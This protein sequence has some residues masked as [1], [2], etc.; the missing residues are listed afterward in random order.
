MHEYRQTIFLTKMFHGHESRTLALN[1]VTYGD[2]VPRI[3]L[4][5]ARLS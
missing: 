5:F 1:K 4:V 3:V 2:Y